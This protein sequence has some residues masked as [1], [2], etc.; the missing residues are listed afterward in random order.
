MALMHQH[1]AL[2]SDILNRGGLTDGL[3]GAVTMTFAIDLKDEGITV[4][5]YCPGW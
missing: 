2:I 1:I 5:C 4:I 3:I